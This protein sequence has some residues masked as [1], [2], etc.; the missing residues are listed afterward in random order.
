[1]EGPRWSADQVEAYL[2][3]FRV[4]ENV[5][6]AINSAIRDKAPDPILHIADFLEARGLEIE[7]AEQAALAQ[8]LPVS[9]P[10]Q[11]QSQLPRPPESQPPL[12]P[13]PPQ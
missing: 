12:P 7:A 10:Q 5:Q 4:E 1:M 2:A 9:Q 13:P 3:R 8:H 11:S 6:E